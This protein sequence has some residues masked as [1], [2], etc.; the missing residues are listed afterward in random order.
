MINKVDYPISFID[1]VDLY[2]NTLKI[3]DEK[4]IEIADFIYSQFKRSFC[5]LKGRFSVLSPGI[6][7]G[8]IENELLKR[9]G[10]KFKFFGVDIN[11]GMIT[12]LESKL[13]K[14]KKHVK[15]I[16]DKEN[17]F[18]HTQEI[19]N[20]KY[21][22][23]FFF[24]VLSQLNKNIQSGWKLGIDKG[25]GYLKKGGLIF[26]SEEYG[27]LSCANC[28][29]QN[30]VLNE[31]N[32]KH[33]ES[34]KISKRLTDIILRKYI[35]VNFLCQSSDLGVVRNWLKY[36]KG[37]EELGVGEW[38]WKNELSVSEYLELFIMWN[39]DMPTWKIW[40]RESLESALRNAIVTKEDKAI[41]FEVGLRIFIY[42]HE[43][44]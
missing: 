17:G 18:L 10:K 20:N 19:P 32:M 13:G 43:N 30:Q 42:H 33:F 44:G 26:I 3:N 22:A 9:Y 28:F 7:N 8:R 15:L 34:I 6:G 31:N 2:E 29:F 11:K 14:N 5:Q 40:E 39:K 21:H 16:V 25:I 4:G 38:K 37:Y 41:S 36:D 27:Q 24:N 1:D 35:P 23:V 12:K